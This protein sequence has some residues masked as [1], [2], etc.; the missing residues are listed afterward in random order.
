MISYVTIGT[1]DFASSCAFYDAVLAV[2]GHRRMHT[3]ADMGW[4]SWAPKDSAR[5]LLWVATPYDGEPATVGN[6]CMV[7]LHADTPAQV[8][9]FHAAALANGGT[10]EGAP[11]ARPQY[12]EGLY[13]AYV[14]DPSGNKLSAYCGPA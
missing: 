12:G 2:F 5:P 9:A 11:G 13:L 8:D 1:H 6:G 7:G 14:R 3:L 10:S 4:A